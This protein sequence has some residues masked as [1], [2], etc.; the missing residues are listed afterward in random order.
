MATQIQV[1][2]SGTY[3]DIDY[4]SFAL[5]FGISTQL[6]APKGS[7]R[8]RPQE[9]ITAGQDVRIIIDGTTVFEGQ[10]LSGGTKDDSGKQVD[11]E[12]PVAELW[13]TNGSFNLT[14]PTD[15]QVLNRALSVAN[16]Q[17]SFTLNYVGTATQLNSDYT[18]Q[19]RSIL[20][21]FRDMMDRT[22]RVWRVDPA[23][24]TITVEPKGNRG[25]WQSLSPSDGI[26]VGSFD[27]G[28]IRTVVNDVNVVGTGGRPVV[29]NASDSGSISTYGRRV[30]TINLDYALTQTEADAHAASVLQPQPVPEGTVTV[31]ETVGNVTQ[32]LANYEVDLSDPS[33]D[34]NATGLVIEK[35]ELRQGRVKLSVG[36]GV[37]ASVNR[38]NRAAKSDGDN[39]RP[40][41]VYDSDRLADNAVLSS[42]LDDLAVTTAKLES[43]AVVN[44]KLDDLSV[45]ETKIQDDSIATPKLQAGAVTA[46]EIEADTITASE[47]AAGT[48]T[49]LE[50][51][52]DTLTAGEIAAD[53][54]TA[55]EI[56]TLFL[57]SGVLTVT[58]PFTGEG[59]EFTTD[60]SLSTDA[61][62][63]KPTGGG[64]S[65]VGLNA[66]RFSAGNFRELNARRGE[67]EP[68]GGSTEISFGANPIGDGNAHF[69]PQT[70]NTGVLGVEI[71]SSIT[72]GWETVFAHNFTTLSPNPIDGVS[73]EAITSADW[74]DKPPACVKTAAREMG[75]S[76][77]PT[78][79]S[80]GHTAVELGTMT[81]WLLEALKQTT[82][83]LDAA[84]KRIADMEERLT[85]LEKQL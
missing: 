38:A 71:S 58:D 77:E 35:Q 5:E 50:V 78:T 85:T 72:Q 65:S 33:K 3:E 6:V 56:D 29:G 16:T 62:V 30:E 69:G 21:V 84:E 41:S 25:T 68:P 52:T 24:T 36:G 73:R 40:G 12:H 1:L 67:I 22:D 51:A 81:N 54:L 13:D 18:S 82:A 74:Y 46:G 7:V 42:K 55:N 64:F 27:E 80:D 70:D 49:A 63:I 26:S 43:N 60:T 53:T 47:I 32:N 79:A 59:V 17:T 15:E 76:D 4:G 61:T 31:P 10:A 11:L 8:T 28:S 2:R 14:S 37:G 34:I 57:D 19:D 75:G 66:T 44:G 20:S 39:A 83:D 48:I 23:G 45:S 9:S